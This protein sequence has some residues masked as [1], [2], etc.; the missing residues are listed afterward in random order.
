MCPQWSSSSADSRKYQLGSGYA[1]IGDW[2]TLEPG[3]PVEME[4]FIAEMGGGG[5]ASMLVVEEQ[6]VDYEKNINGAPIFPIFKTAELERDLIEGI[7]EF[8]PEDEVCLTNGPVFCDYDTIGKISSTPAN[9]TDYPSFESELFNAADAAEMRTWDAADG[10]ALEAGFVAAIGDKVVLKDSR[11]KQRRIPFSRFS[12]K[13]REFI[14]LASP[15]DFDISF[16]KQSTLQPLKIYPYNQWVPPKIFDHV[17]SAKLRQTSAGAYGH[18]LHVEFFTVGEEVDGDNYILL[19]RQESTFMPTKENG[20]F[21]KLS[22]DPVE[23]CAYVAGY[24]G[25]QRRGTKYGGYLVVI[26]DENGKIVDYGTSHKWLPGILGE[27][28]HLP[29]GKHFD[30][31]GA[32]VFPPR[33]KKIVPEMKFL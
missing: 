18:G 4:V 20:R 8:L 33:P 32:R 7:Y 9:V 1:E 21:H 22:G 6:G 23:L 25:D 30:K 11:G 2:I 27:L 15:P 14:E 13:D 5:F 26:K 28:R 19:D 3:V 29:V 16:S 10:H 12:E 17:F 24:Y 31:T